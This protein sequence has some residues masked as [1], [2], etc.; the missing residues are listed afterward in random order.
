MTMEIDDLD[1]KILEYLQV[2]SRRPFLEIARNL[3]VSGGTVHAR[4]NRMREL[5]VIQGSKVVIDYEKLGFSVTA[6]VGIKLAKAKGFKQIQEQMLLIPEIVE[7]HYTTG[8]Y[9]LLT[10][11]VVASMRDLYRVL[12]DKLQAIEDIQSTETFVVLDTP[13]MRDPSLNS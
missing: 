4:V 6:F 12:S 5:G 2:D 10:K 8:A 7:V 11:I 9:S 13:L 3:K 1:A